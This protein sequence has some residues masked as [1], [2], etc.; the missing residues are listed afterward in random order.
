MPTVGAPSTCQQ[1]PR[2]SRDA[3]KTWLFTYTAGGMA[4]ELKSLGETVLR[5]RGALMPIVRE[6]SDY[7]VR[8]G[9]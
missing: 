5:P 1:L 3:I 9:A 4:S 8:R 7:T 2:C 6:I